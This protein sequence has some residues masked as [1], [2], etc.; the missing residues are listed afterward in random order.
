V[1]RQRDYRAEYRRRMERAKARGL[2]PAQ[3]HGHARRAKQQGVIDLVRSGRL[4]PIAPKRRRPP[5]RVE[6]AAGTLV[7]TRSRKYLAQQ[8][9]A[10][11]REG[12]RVAIYATVRLPNGDFRTAV[13][14]G[15]NLGYVGGDDVEVMDDLRMVI[16]DDP[17]M[18]GSTID[19]GLVL[20]AIR[21]SG[22]DVDAG[23]AAMLA[24]DR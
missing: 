14:D 11:Q 3:A 19:A 15:R 4:D 24:G 1:A 6:S 12:K 21:E 23:L 13:I 18:V 22:G 5:R 8:L 20:D 9:R 2:T 16:S 7:N 17:L 10:A